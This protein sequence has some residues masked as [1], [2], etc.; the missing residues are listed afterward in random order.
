MATMESWTPDTTLES[1]SL[2]IS[3]ASV[4]CGFSILA[5]GFAVQIAN[6]FFQ[7]KALAGILIA[8]A[9]SALAVA[10]PQIAVM[11]PFH[12]RSL[13][14]RI[15]LLI[16]VAY[17][18]F[19]VVLLH[20]SHPPIDVLVYEN[21]GV[22]ALIHGHDPYAFNVTHQ[23]N[24]GP[25]E[26]VYY[27]PGVSVNGR[28][29]VGVPYPPLTLLWI[30]PGYLAG[31][32]RYSFLLAVWLTSCLIFYLSP[33]VKGLTAAV[34]LLF[35]P[36]TFFLLKMGWTEPLM[37]VTLAIT[38]VA[39]CRAPRMLPLALGLFFASKQYS[40][41]A[42]PLCV[43]LL[44]KP[45]WQKYWLL[46]AKA[47]GVAA[48]LTLPMAFWDFR[49]F[50]W[51]LVTFQIV[52]PFRSDAL[53]VSTLLVKFGFSPIPQ[54][55]VLAAVLAAIVFA[56]IRSPRTPSGFAASLAL[57]SLIF[58]ELNKQAFCNYYFFSAGALCLAIASASLNS[59]VAVF[60][61]ARVPIET[62]GRKPVDIPSAQ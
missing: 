59:K 22:Q 41:L 24:S 3:L 53:S 8:T 31:D 13:V 30:L 35:V 45:S 4:L 56:L 11:V 17:L 40:L 10:S 46:L 58:F 48:I 14:S 26:I 12:G 38:M 62:A 52:A 21:D 7:R 20:R 9:L 51:S 6:G 19:G 44:P 25:S 42:V 33:D 54:W 32:V 15:Y 18:L 2:S 5:L 16:S 47:G 29:H 34:L 23:D 55:F 61:V 36:D 49:G 28:I 37:L 43:L 50:W 1:E 27:G 39:A 60:T 57:I